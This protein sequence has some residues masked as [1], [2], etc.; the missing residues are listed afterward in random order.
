MEWYSKC[1]FKNSKNVLWPFINCIYM[2]FW[3]LVLWWDEIMKFKND[4]EMSKK[5][6]ENDVFWQNIS[7][8]DTWKRGKTDYLIWMM[9]EFDAITIIIILIT[10]LASI[11]GTLNVPKKILV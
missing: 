10:L 1:V 5:K 7:E 4:D 3:D 6:N 9:G 11:N 8:D 2:K